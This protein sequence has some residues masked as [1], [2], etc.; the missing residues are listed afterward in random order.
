MATEYDLM[1]GI[2]RRCAL[3]ASMLSQYQAKNFPLTGRS[4]ESLCIYSLG[5]G[6]RVVGMSGLCDVSGREERGTTALTPTDQR[7]PIEARSSCSDQL[8]SAHTTRALAD[9]YS[10]PTLAMGTIV[11]APK[12]PRKQ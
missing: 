12:L 5:M 2:P 11:E 7:V 1:R 3:S 6:C 8:A 4:Q 9:S 10:T